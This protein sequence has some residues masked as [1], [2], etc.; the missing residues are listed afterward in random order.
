M[1]VTDHGENITL[2]INKEFF[3]DFLKT[4]IRSAKAIAEWCEDEDFRVTNQIDTYLF[5][6]NAIKDAVDKPS[7]TPLLVGGIPDGLNTLLVE[8]GI[9]YLDENEIK[10]INGKDKLDAQRTYGI[11]YLPAT[12]KSD[13]HAEYLF[14]RIMDAV[15]A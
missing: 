4:S 14:H 13:G 5:Q 6:G 7:D 15:N 2:T 1:R 10:V 12:L 3:L 11:P 8:L 9:S